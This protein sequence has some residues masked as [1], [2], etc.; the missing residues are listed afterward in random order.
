M[1]ATLTALAFVSAAT[2]AQGHSPEGVVWQTAE[3]V[4]S[5]QTDAKCTAYDAS[6]YQAMTNWQF[7]GTWKPTAYQPYRFIGPLTWVE[8]WNSVRTFTR[9]FRVGTFEVEVQM[10]DLWADSD[11]KARR[12]REDQADSVIRQVAQSVANLPGV[13]TQRLPKM[14][15]HFVPKRHSPASYYSGTNL[16]AFDARYIHTPAGEPVFLGNLPHHRNFEELLA[17][18]LAHALDDHLGWASAST[19][20]QNALLDAPCF[21]T[22]YARKND[23]ERFAEGLVAFL[24]FY[25]GRDSMAADDRRTL[26]LRLG[27]A[28]V[29]YFAKLLSP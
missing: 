3:H 2:L 10:P 14:H 20:W 12:L 29:R 26:R 13:L 22:E 17:H 4:Q 27:N 15:M 24:Q 18:E 5:A 11:G 6:P 21:V 28:K 7:V 19:A 23:R 1:R 16:V 8:E 9:T 25:A